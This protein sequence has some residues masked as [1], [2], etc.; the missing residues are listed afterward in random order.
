MSTSQ[1]TALIASLDEDPAD[2]LPPALQDSL[3]RHRE[4]LASMVSALRAAGLAEASI[5]SHLSVLIDSYR[6]ELSAALLDLGG[7]A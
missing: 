5:E 3:A 2:D 6:A 7:K 4:N 1:S